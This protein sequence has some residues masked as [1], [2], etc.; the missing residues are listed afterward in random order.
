[1]TDQE[2][3]NRI[4]HDFLRH[5]VLRLGLG[6]HPDTDFHDY[7]NANGKRTYPIPAANMLNNQLLDV[8]ERFEA[9]G[10]D[11]YQYVMD[12]PEWQ[13]AKEELEQ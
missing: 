4:D 8:F 9:R 6:F 11:I 13:M 2:F 3:Q 1:M 12:L 10:I 5:C 7:V